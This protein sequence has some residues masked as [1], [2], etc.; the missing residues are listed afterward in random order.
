MT[1]ERILHVAAEV[2]PLLKT[3]GLADVA[4]A[5]PD[6]LHALGHD[7]RVL[8]PGYGA[9]IDHARGAGPVHTVAA[10]DDA[11]LLETQLPGGCRAWLYETPAFRARGDRPYDGPDH[12]PWPDN[13]QRFDELCRAATAIAADR[14]GLDWRPDVV[15][16]HDWH[17]GLLPVH[18][19]LARVPAASVFSI[20]NL[21]YRG[22]FPLG[23]RADLRLPGWLEH[24]QAMELHGELSFIKGGIAFA[25]RVSTVSATYAQEITTH[26]FGEGLEGLLA[27]RGTALSG[28]TNGIDT[29]S[30]DPATDPVLTTHYDADEPGGKALAREALLAETGLEAGRRT[31]VIAYIGRLAGQKGVDLLLAALDRLVALPAVLVVLGDGDP[32]LRKALSRAAKARPRRVYTQFGF[33]EAMARRIYAGADMLIM[34][35]RFEPC[36]LSQLNAMRY[37]TI[38]VV[39]RTGGLAETVVDTTQAT[40]EDG[41]ATGFQFDGFTAAALVDAA[42]RARDWFIKPSRWRGLVDNAMRRDSS[43]TRSAREY[44]SLYR[45]AREARFDHLSGKTGPRT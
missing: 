4:G 44:V 28:I 22:L 16:A 6:A 3:G 40:L 36:G 29:R 34:P 21:A 42:R 24:W 35:S 27:H 37:G 45:D 2:V 26:G 30:W 19:Q 15:H 20:H 31:P 33:D 5:L 11:R 32:V 8:M 10:W 13:A 25:D 17:T 43:W 9:A 38:P 39:H 41:T 18:L 14:L 12:A 1:A 7:V 23:V